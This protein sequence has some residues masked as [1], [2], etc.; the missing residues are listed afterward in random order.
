MRSLLTA[1]MLAFLAAPAFAQ[2]ETCP[3]TGWTVTRLEAL[4]KDGFK[5]PDSFQR[6]ELAVALLPC[7]GDSK[8]ELRDGIAFEALS[9]WMRSGQLDLATMKTLRS[10]LLTAI[11]SADAEGFRA[12]FSVLVLAEVAR[13]DAEWQTF[14]NE[15]TDPKPLVSWRTAFSSE[16]GI[17]ERH[18]VRAFLL[19]VYA[20]A[21]SSDDRGIR[22][23]VPHVTAALKAVQ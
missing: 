4:E 10:S 23:L 9:T 8:P 17:K 18:N 3:P 5:V 2:R 13:T 16:A 14:F 22:Q 11:A 6:H 15:I 19:S 7:L 21:S 20:S 12:S 1:C